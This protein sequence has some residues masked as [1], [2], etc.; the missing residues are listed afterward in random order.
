MNLTKTKTDIFI[1]EEIFDIKVHSS[2]VRLYKSVD[3][4]L[5]DIAIEQIKS[6]LILGSNIDIPARLIKMCCE[7]FIPIHILTNQHKHH[8]SLHFASQGEICSRQNQFEATLNPA[9][10]LKLAQQ[11]IFQKILTQNVLSQKWGYHLEISKK[12]NTAKDTFSLLGIEGST[13]SLYW[14]NFATQIPAEFV[15]NGRIKYPCIDP[16]NSLLSL[17]YGLLFT[18]CQTALTLRGLDPYLGILHTTNNDRPALVC[19]FIEIFRVLAVDCWVL[20]LLQQKVFVPEDFRIQS[21]GT[22]TLKNEQKNLFFK[23]WYKRL[24]HFQFDTKDDTITI[25]DMLGQNAD[26]LLEWFEDIVAKKTRIT[27]E[28]GNTRLI[29]FTNI[30]QFFITSQI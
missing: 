18:Q 23:L 1:T 30:D 28:L 9:W 11:L 7:N 6:V 8:G 5:T 13:A 24:K 27:K 15:W 21:S 22:C 2:F 26:L 10:K 16:V 25:Y 19:D 12:I 17:A 29:T 14:D 4:I 3:E 20:G